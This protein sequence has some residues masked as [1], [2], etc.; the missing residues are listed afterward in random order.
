MSKIVD[1]TLPDI[2]DFDQVDV[3]EVIVSA[4]DTVAVDDPLIT[5]ESDK[6]TMEVP[7]PYSGKIIALTVQE[8][9]KVATGDVIGKIELAEGENSAAEAE[10]AAESQQNTASATEAKTGE[11]N[12][13]G[14]PSAASFTGEAD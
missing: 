12:F 8:G 11:Q 4:G 3:I 1:I 5:L 14:T 10:T 7:S 13:R 6:A 9:D 2:G